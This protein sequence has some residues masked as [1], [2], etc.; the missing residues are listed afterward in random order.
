VAWKI[1][2][3]VVDWIFTLSNTTVAIFSSRRDQIVFA[4]GNHHASGL[5]L[6][7]E[8]AGAQPAVVDPA[9]RDAVA[10]LGQMH[11]LYGLQTPVEVSIFQLVAQVVETVVPL[12]VN[13]SQM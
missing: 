2:M 7:A 1:S 10:A 6:L 4:A 3:P 5:V 13:G 9:D 11:L 12:M 8:V